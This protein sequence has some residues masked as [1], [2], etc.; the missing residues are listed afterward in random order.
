MKWLE[1]GRL[2]AAFCA[3]VGLDLLSGC[4]P[5]AAPVST[6]LVPVTVSPSAASDSEGGQTMS[7]TLGST[8]FR[9]GEAIPSKYTCDGDN[10]SV[11][12]QW[13]DPPVGTR[14]FAITVEDPDAPSG[15]FVHWVIY[16]IPANSRDL[17]EDGASEANLP[18]GSQNGANSARRTGYMGPCPPSGTHRYVFRLYALDTTLNLNAGATKDQL[19][20]AMQGHTLADAELMGT[21]TRK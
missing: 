14:S 1:A 17:P 6:A 7:F 19:L 13:A 20:K 2:C 21:Y 11:P 9:Q 5:G 12:L 16:N 8:A 10:V 18:E 4:N 15:T 3:A